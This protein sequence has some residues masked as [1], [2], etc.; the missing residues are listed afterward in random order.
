MS[1]WLE[2]VQEEMRLVGDQFS[3]AV[4]LTYCIPPQFDIKLAL[5]DPSKAKHKRKIEGHICHDVVEFSNQH[6]LDIKMIENIA[7]IL[8]ALSNDDET[9]AFTLWTHTMIYFPYSTMQIYSVPRN[10]CRKCKIIDEYGRITNYIASP[11][12]E[13]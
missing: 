5:K 9:M 11:N 1:D 3:N 13:D 10:P 8:I 12:M 6:Q 2:I 7:D 4:K